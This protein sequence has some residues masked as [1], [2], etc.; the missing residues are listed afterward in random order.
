MMGPWV[1][2]SIMAPPD[3]PVPDG[4]NVFLRNNGPFLRAK[5]KR[6]QIHIIDREEIAVKRWKC[7]SASAPET[8]T[9]RE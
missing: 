8:S 5:V 3:R 2:P 6:D 1:V 4:T 7:V 9:P